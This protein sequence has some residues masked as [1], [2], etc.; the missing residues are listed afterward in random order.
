M[1]GLIWFVQIVHYPLF[2]KVGKENWLA[3]EKAHTHQTSFV[4]APLMI[5]ELLTAIA[6]IFWGWNI[7]IW[8]VWLNLV[9]VIGL[10][11]ST[12][13]IQVPLHNQL[14]KRFSEAAIRK[15]VNSNWIRTILWTLRALIWG[16]LVF[17]Q[18]L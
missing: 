7:P 12:F 13:L 2:A 9:M 3:Y 10:W 4:T 11:L 17:E 14:L 8:W 15:L 18:I 5:V 16:Y 1:L 6:I